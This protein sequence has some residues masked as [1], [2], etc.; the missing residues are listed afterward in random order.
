MVNYMHCVFVKIFPLQNVEPTTESG[1]YAEPCTFPT[2]ILVW[3]V[4]KKRKDTQD[5][6]SQ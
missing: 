6:S 3:K 2:D 5:I 4:W 1:R